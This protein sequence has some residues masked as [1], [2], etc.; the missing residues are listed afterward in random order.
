[1]FIRNAVVALLVLVPMHVHAQSGMPTEQQCRKLAAV[2]DGPLFTEW[3]QARGRLQA[4]R[5]GYDALDT[6]YADLR[7]TSDTKR[8]VDLLGA[9][10]HVAN[11]STNLIQNA[12]AIPGLKSLEKG[13]YA[14]IQNLKDAGS[15]AGAGSEGEITEAIADIAAQANVVTRA[16]VTVKDLVQDSRAMAA[17]LAAAQQVR[18]SLDGQMSYLS[19]E[20]SRLDASIARLS[21]TLK[22]LQGIKDDIDRQCGSRAAATV[23]QP[24]QEPVRAPAPVQQSGGPSADCESLMARVA[25][26]G[27]HMDTSDPD[28][29][30]AQMTAACGE[31]LQACA[32]R[33]QQCASRMQ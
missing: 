22:R 1:M 32:A 33:L 23:R 20:M 5:N 26:E 19:R 24:A 28:R 29:M 2:R 9:F 30:V 31:D 25:S 18:E 4:Y 8:W 16:M 3:D 10:A 14:L 7:S 6:A 11:T 15:L 27:A 12:A 21:S 13:A 17:D